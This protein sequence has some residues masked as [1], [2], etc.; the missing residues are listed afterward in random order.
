VGD[1]LRGYFPFH[2]VHIVTNATELQREM[3]ITR[4][5]ARAAGWV[6]DEENETDELQ[7]DCD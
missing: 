6:S 2:R 4:G 7:S 1:L 5:Q 3:R